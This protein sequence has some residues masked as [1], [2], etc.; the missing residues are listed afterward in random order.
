MYRRVP[1]S[2]RNSFPPIRRCCE[3]SCA[4]IYTGAADIF[5]PARRAGG[6]PPRLPSRQWRVAVGADSISLVAIE[7]PESP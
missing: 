7:Q 4:R 3:Q 2:I 1:C 5:H 6:I